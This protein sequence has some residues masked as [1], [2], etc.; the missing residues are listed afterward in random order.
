M[1]R[2]H[3]V[4]GLLWAVALLLAGCR[5]L[6]VA[7]EEAGSAVA[8]MAGNYAVEFRLGTGTP[9]AEG[10][11]PSV[12]RICHRGMGGVREAVEAVSAH[13]AQGFASVVDGDP[14]SHIRLV[15]DKAGEVLVIEEDIPNDCGP[16]RNFLLVRTGASGGPE[17]LYLAVPERGQ[18]IM[19]ATSGEYPS[20]ETVFA[21]GMVVRYAGSGPET[22]W[23][24]FLPSREAPQWP[25]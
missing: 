19:A 17:V 16:C 14:R 9:V 18:G 1:S 15:V 3:R 2:G 13:S 8:W 24:R 10:Y 20:V 12:Y 11:E 25:G 6:R 22:V 5:G 23:F 21:E 4:M 7:K